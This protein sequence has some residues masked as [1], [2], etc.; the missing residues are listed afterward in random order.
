[1]VTLNPV[2]ANPTSTNSEGIPATFSYAP[3]GNDAVIKLWPK[4]PTSWAATIVPMEK[5]AH[6]RVTSGNIGDADIFNHPNQYNHILSLFI[7]DYLYLYSQ[8]GDMTAIAMGGNQVQIRGTLARAI[9]AAQA[10]IPS[11]AIYID[12]TGSQPKMG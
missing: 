8:V 11:E 10:I 1:L 3:S 12:E 7:L 4:P 2:S 6:T 9:N 5:I